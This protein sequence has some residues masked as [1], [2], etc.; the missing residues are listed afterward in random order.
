MMNGASKQAGRQAGGRE[1]RQASYP[2]QRHFL[3]C[4]YVALFCLDS[5]P[6]DQHEFLHVGAHSAFRVRDGVAPPDTPEHQA[7]SEA[8]E[9]YLLIGASMEAPA[10]QQQPRMYIHGMALKSRAMT[11]G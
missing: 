5:P 10:Q 2:K 7:M 6:A 4:I 8:I 1:G 11:P 3:T 9:T